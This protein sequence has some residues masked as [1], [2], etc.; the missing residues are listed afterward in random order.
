[1]IDEHTARM[2]DGYTLSMTCPYCGV[3]EQNAGMVDDNQGECVC[4]GCNRTYTYERIS[5]Y[6]TCAIENPKGFQS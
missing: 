6:R 1:M 4:D 5:T 3:D 2:I